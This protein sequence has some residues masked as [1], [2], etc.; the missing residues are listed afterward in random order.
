[1]KQRY[2][3]YHRIAKIDA[4]DED[5]QIDSLLYTMGETADKV[6]ELLTAANIKP[7][8][9]ILE[10]DKYF[11]PKTNIA[12]A[13]VK[14]N[15]RNQQADET[16]E[17]YIRELNHLIEKCNFGTQN[18]DQLKYRLL[19][20]MTDKELSLDLQQLPDAELT[21]SSHHRH[22]G[23]RKHTARAERC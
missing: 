16:N 15:S 14:F 19:T 20:G 11:Q 7:Y 5:F 2:Q 1:M 12:H 9:G 18:D 17:C 10:F 6:V 21:L 8:E 3:R 4:E 22:E 23:Q 13:V